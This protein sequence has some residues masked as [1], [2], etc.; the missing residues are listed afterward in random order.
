MSVIYT[1]IKRVDKKL[2]NEFRTLSTAI[3]SDAMNRLN[4]MNAEI[5]PIFKDVNVAGSAVTVQCMASDN[6]MVHK[7]IYVAEPGDIL[8]V[9]ARGHKDTSVWGYIMTKA[10]KTRGI[11]AVVIDG[12]IRDLKENREERFPLFCRGSVPAGSQ[13]NWGGNINVPIQC[14]SVQVNPGDII[15]GDDDG[16]VVVPQYMAEQVLQK[17]KERVRM[18]EAW[19]NEIR[20]GTTTLELLG[21][22]KKL[23]QLQ[24]EIREGVTYEGKE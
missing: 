17:A 2:I 9:D 21:L 5:K 11:V 1:K 20:K 14:G 13:K 8:V 24:V 4:S 7:A 10:C 19:L 23:E 6:I 3:V 18:E 12:S 15:V 22:D 16:C